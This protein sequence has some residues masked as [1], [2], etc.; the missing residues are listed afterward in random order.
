MLTDSL[1]PYVNSS[2]G[3]RINMPKLEYLFLYIDFSEN[4]WTN[5][6]IPCTS[7]RICCCHEK[8][9]GCTLCIHIIQWK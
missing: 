1:Q 7:I 9:D 6:T 5:I 8:L 2:S 4:L 3:P